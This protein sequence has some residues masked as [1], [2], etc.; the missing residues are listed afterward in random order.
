[1]QGIVYVLSNPAMPGM[2]KIGKTTA[3]DPQ[4]RLDQLYNTSVPVPFECEVAVRVQD[5]GQ[6]EQVL[7]QAF[8]QCRVNPR[9]EFFKIEA[10]DVIPLLRYLGDEDVTPNVK[11]DG[12]AA[13]PVDVHAGEKLRRQRRPNMDFH[14]MGILDGAELRLYDPSSERSGI[15]IVVGPRTVSVDEEEMSITAAT[16]K[17]FDVD[18]AKPPG[19][20]WTYEGRLL[21]DIYNE[22]YDD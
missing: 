17:F 7:H 4:V 1:M 15:A 11:P 19:Y 12:D 14:E 16:R 20:S 21:R 18:Y 9:R 22:T 5:V 6:C 2:V 3:E 8:A 13:D 10:E